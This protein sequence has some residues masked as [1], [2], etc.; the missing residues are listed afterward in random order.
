MGN[1]KHLNKDEHKDDREIVDAFFKDIGS[2]CDIAH[3]KAKFGEDA[4]KLLKRYDLNEDGTVSQAEFLG[5]IDKKYE[6][7]PKEAA[8]LV[9]K[10]KKHTSKGWF[11]G[12][13][14]EERAAKAREEAENAE[15][16]AA[17]LKNQ[18]AAAAEAREEAEAEAAKKRKAAKAAKD[19][20]AQADAAEA[21]AAKAREEAEAEASKKRKATEDAQAQADA[22]VA[23]AAAKRVMK[24]KAPKGPSAECEVKA[25]KGPSAECEVKAPKG[26]SVECEVKAPK[27]QS[28][29]CEVKA[30][31]G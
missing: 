29:E 28:V 2:P 13:S 5:V 16:E 30:P 26:P 4:E 8:K 22:A 17:A 3:V 15:L 25:P 21:A 24:V 31:K 20:Q 10:L 6:T 27:G 14:P 12:L 18:E 23:E 1:L 19:A 9:K 11:K 7:D